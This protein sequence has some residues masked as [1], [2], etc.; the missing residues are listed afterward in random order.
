MLD[1]GVDHVQVAFARSEMKV[2]A[3]VV[4]CADRGSV[5]G[6]WPAQEACRGQWTVTCSV[7]VA[8]LLHVAAVGGEANARILHRLAILACDRLPQAGQSP[9]SSRRRKARQVVLK[10]RRVTD[11]SK[12]AS[13][14]TGEMWARFGETAFPRLLARPLACLPSCK[15]L[16]ATESRRPH[17]GGPIDPM[18]EELRNLSRR[19]DRYF[20]SIHEKVR[21]IRARD[22]LTRD[23]LETGRKEKGFSSSGVAV[24]GPCFGA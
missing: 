5:S 9:V 10:C 19:S 23:G 12:K 18:E 1:E 3:L 13:G 11:C 22:R 8:A 14:E 21:P 2:G 17:K 24:Q 6:G 15:R 20:R 7:G 16:L 4:I